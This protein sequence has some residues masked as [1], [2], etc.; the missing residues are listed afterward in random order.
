MA[1]NIGSV[2]GGLVFPIRCNCD[3]DAVPNVHYA[4]NAPVLISTS[5]RFSLNDILFQNICLVLM[6][7]Y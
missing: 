1:G 7:V 2:E 3:A 6:T 4:N 5:R